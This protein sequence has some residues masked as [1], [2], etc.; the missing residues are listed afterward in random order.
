MYVFRIGVVSKK[1][2]VQQIWSNVRRTIY[3]RVHAVK[4]YI[5]IDQWFSNFFVPGALMFLKKCTEPRKPEIYIR[6]NNSY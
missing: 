5:T 2:Y 4:L 3:V 6:D 1:V